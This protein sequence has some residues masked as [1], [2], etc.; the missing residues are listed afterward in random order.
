MGLVGLNAKPWKLSKKVLPQH[1]DHAGVM[2]HGSYLNWLEE[3]RIKAL[4]QTGLSYSDLS[5]EGFEL[6]VIELKIKYISSLHHGDEVIM[7]S[8]VLGKTGL[9]VPWETNFLKNG[10]IISAKA[11]VELVITRLDKKGTRLVRKYP[12]FLSAAIRKL[13]EG[14]SQ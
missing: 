11:Y 1:T 12:S 5:K 2:W 13:Q 8:S 10:N 3:A 7:E 9:R 14:P 6:P 4:A